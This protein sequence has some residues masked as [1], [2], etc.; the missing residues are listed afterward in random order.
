MSDLITCL[1]KIKSVISL[2]SVETEKNSSKQSRVKY[3][4]WVW[5]L[6]TDLRI[7]MKVWRFH[8]FYAIK[9]NCVDHNI[10]FENW[11]SLMK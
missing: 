6:N 7:F 1:K 10:L 8:S 9:K 5:Q 4:K 11:E 2:F 3:Q